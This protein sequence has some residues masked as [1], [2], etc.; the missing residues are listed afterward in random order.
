MKN[1]IDIDV[2][3]EDIDKAIVA[4]KE[5]KAHHNGCWGDMCPASQ[6][7]LRTEPI[8][9]SWA[10]HEILMLETMENTYYY[11]PTKKYTNFI[12]LVD[13]NIDKNSEKIRPSK[14]R[15]HLRKTIPN[16]LC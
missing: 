9:R 13:S 10:T 1:Y 12:T 14:F 8:I 5:Y 11:S 15:L 4:R 2:T 16:Y 3:Q 7:V 6:S